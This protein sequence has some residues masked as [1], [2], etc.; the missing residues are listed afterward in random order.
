MTDPREIHRMSIASYQS[1]LANE[2][3]NY[4]QA[5]AANDM[6]GMVD[7]ANRMAG[8]RASMRELD[9]MLA[10][11]I[12]PQPQRGP[13]DRYGLTESEREVAKNFTQDPRMSEEDKLRTYAEQKARYQRARATG[14]YRDDQGRVTR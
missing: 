10:E 7:S 6:E 13:V 11:A 3:A 2:N 1:V 9:R 12:H 8:Y 14:A 5:Q 4:M